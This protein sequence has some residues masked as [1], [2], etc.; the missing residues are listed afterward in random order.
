MWGSHFATG[1]DVVCG[2]RGDHWVIA[3]VTGLEGDYRYNYQ[4]LEY[5]NGELRLADAEPFQDGWIGPKVH[6]LTNRESCSLLTGVQA[7][8]ITFRLDLE[9]F[10]EM[11]NVVRVT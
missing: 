9:K 4:P 10:L 2:W 11:V 5:R 8:H 7:P 3:L 6:R 1:R